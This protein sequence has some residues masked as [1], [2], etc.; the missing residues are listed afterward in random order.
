MRRHVHACAAD[1]VDAGCLQC[2]GA[3]VYMEF[4]TGHSGVSSAMSLHLE[5]AGADEQELQHFLQLGTLSSDVEQSQVA[6]A[7]AASSGLQWFAPPCR[8][9]VWHSS[10]TQGDA[11]EQADY[12]EPEE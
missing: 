2:G 10:H 9:W 3:V 12:E 5:R 6:A 8:T 11:A 4:C 7:V 1:A